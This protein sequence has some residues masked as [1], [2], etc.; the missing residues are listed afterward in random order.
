MAEEVFEAVVPKDSGTPL[1]YIRKMNI[2]EGT[3][4][5]KDMN[6]EANQKKNRAHRND[7][8]SSLTQAAKRRIVLKA[9]G[10][11]TPEEKENYLIQKALAK[12]KGKGQFSSRPIGYELRQAGGRLGGNPLITVGR[13]APN[14][15][16]INKPFTASGYRN[17][18]PLRSR[19]YPIYSRPTGFDRNLVG[20]RRASAYDRYL[21]R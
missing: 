6:M 7:F 8:I 5:P 4:T 2:A 10:R 18:P 3:V 16:L 9:Q 21:R 20:G 14:P 12:R 17:M 1:A 19:N 11:L 13:Q 15:Y